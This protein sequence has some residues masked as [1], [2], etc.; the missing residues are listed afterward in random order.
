MSRRRS[1]ILSE[2]EL[3]VMRAV[4]KLGKA[5][6]KEIRQEMGGESAGAYTSIATMLKFLEKKGVLRHVQIGRSYYYSANTSQSAEQQK[7]LKFILQGYFEGNWKIL[8]KLLP[9]ISRMTMEERSMIHNL[10]AELKRG[11]SYP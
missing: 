11:E 2:R 1:K 10:I 8:L 7:A 3:E 4:W 5:S 6:V 9:R